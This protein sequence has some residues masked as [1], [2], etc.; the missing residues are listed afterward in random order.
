MGGPFERVLHHFTAV[1]IV[2]SAYQ[3]CQSLL[4]L[5]RRSQI[6]V[7]CL[8]HADRNALQRAA[9]LD[10]SPALIRSYLEVVARL[11]FAL[12]HGECLVCTLNEHIPPSGRI[13]LLMAY[14]SRLDFQVCPLP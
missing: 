10:H 14:P 2:V 8:Q 5:H 13:R 6:A 3:W 4:F 11:N 7:I 9:S 12:Y 1:W